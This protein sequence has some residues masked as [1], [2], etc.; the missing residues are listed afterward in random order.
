VW[1]PGGRK[2][3]DSRTELLFQQQVEKVALRYVAEPVR[4][5]LVTYERAR[6]AL[7]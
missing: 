7:V 1:L 6:K 3:A 4:R 2:R 5:V